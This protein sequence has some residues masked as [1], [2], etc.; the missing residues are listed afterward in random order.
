MR[1][2]LRWSIEEPAI[3]DMLGDHEKRIRTFRPHRVCG[4]PGCDTALSIYNGSRFC[5]E[6]EHA[7]RR[8]VRR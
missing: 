7:A 1:T 8:H 6:H 3:A 2:L 4:M 5:A